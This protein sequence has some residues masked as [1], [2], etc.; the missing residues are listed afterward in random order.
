[1]AFCPAE[2]TKKLPREIVDK[3]LSFVVGRGGYLSR[4]LVDD[5]RWVGKIKGLDIV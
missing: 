4:E 2:G 5:G 3:V 1:M